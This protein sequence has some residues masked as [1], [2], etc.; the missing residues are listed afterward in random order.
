LIPPFIMEAGF[1][2][3]METESFLTVFGPL[4]LWRTMKGS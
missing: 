3:V 2:S 4:Y 1:G